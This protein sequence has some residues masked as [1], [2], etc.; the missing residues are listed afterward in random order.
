MAK[1]RIRYLVSRQKKDGTDRYY[2]QPDCALRQAG[3]KMRRLSSILTEAMTEAEEINQAVDQWRANI[4]LEPVNEKPGTIASLIVDY[5]NSRLFDKLAPR[6][7]H[8]YRHYLACIGEWAGDQM[9]I[10]INSRIVQTLY[11]TQRQ[12]SPR[13]AQYLI[14]V[15]RLLFTHAERM[16]MIPK[17]SN[18]ATKT[19]MDYRAKKGTIWE[20]EQVTHVA[21]TADTM[22]YFAVGTAIILNEWLGQRRGDIIRLPVNA[23]RDGKLYIKQS[24]TGAEVVLPID[25]VPH[26]KD[27]ITAQIAFNTRYSAPSPTLIRTLDGAPMTDTAIIQAFEKIRA[28][29]A[30][31]MPSCAGLVMKHGCPRQA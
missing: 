23:Y 15:L 10:N 7:K 28:V 30:E 2:W 25:I 17:G 13:K 20:P 21:A 9:A 18:P 4:L 16:G 19:V 14:A 6:T 29:A 24:K 11:D 8:D 3:W 22:G 5:K 31:T 26:L 1:F 12:S 27:R